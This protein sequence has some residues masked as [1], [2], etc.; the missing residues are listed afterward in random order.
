M[1]GEKHPVF[2]NMLELFERVTNTRK[3][4]RNNLFTL[5]RSQKVSQ[6]YSKLCY[7][8]IRGKL[9]PQVG[10][11]REKKCSMYEPAIDGDV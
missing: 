7:H 8:G 9:S 5:S 10:I 2:Y 11:N 4:A 1:N 3:K 6:C